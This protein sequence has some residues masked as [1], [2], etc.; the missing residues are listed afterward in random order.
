MLS[1]P[2][3]GSDAGAASTLAVYKVIPDDLNLWGV[4]VLEHDSHPNHNKRPDHAPCTCP[5]PSHRAYFL[6]ISN[7]R[8][9]TLSFHDLCLK[10]LT[11]H[12]NEV[13]LFGAKAF[14]LLIVLML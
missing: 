3:N 8:Q 13:H 12:D 14:H 7:S 10:D 9:P 2:G 11:M 6:A 4:A 1:E 5:N